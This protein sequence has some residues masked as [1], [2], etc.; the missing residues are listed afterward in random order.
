VTGPENNL[1][2]VL[3]HRPRDNSAEN[4][5]HTDRTLI[6]EFVTTTKLVN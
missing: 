4:P 1:R 5:A 2:L 3:V 6:K